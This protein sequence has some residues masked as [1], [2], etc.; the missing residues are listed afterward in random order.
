MY[1]YHENI[2]FRHTTGVLSL[3]IVLAALHVF[4]HFR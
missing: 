2:S 4:A 3:L 1:G